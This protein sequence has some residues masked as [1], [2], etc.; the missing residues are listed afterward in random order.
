MRER[1]KGIEAVRQRQRSATYFNE[2]GK[3]ALER[4]ISGSDYTHVFIAHVEEFVK[5]DTTVRERAE[6]SL[7]LELSGK[8]GICNG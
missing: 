3:W 1:A 6:R 8:R 5:L 7:L 4:A 2:L